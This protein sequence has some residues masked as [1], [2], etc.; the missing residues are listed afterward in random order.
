MNKLKKILTALVMLCL[1]I[2]ILPANTLAVNDDITLRIH[3]YRPDG[4]Y[5]GWNLWL[6]DNDGYYETEPLYQF[7]AGNNEMICTVTVPTG[8]KH[9]GYIVRYGEWE[10]K[11]VEHDQFINLNGILSGT[12]DFYITSGVPSQEAA[13]YVPS[14]DQLC[15]DGFMVLGQDVVFG[16]IVLSA[17][18]SIDYDG[19]NRLDVM[20]SAIP[21]YEVTADLFKVMLQDNI[22][23]SITNIEKAPSYLTP[24]ASSY[25]L[26]LDEELSFDK[27]YSIQFQ[28]SSQ[29]ITM[30]SVHIEDASYETD[31]DFLGIQLHLSPQP[32]L[33]QISTAS[34]FILNQDYDYIAIKKLTKVA[35]TYYL[36]LYQPLKTGTYYIG[37]L[38]NSVVSVTYTCDHPSH[39]SQGICD[40]CADL[41][42]HS[43]EDNGFC[44]CGEKAP[45]ITDPTE[46]P[47]EAAPTTPDVDPTIVPTDGATTTPDEYPTQGQDSKPGRDDEDEADSSQ[48]GSVFDLIDPVTLIAI[49]LLAVGVVAIAAIIIILVK[50]KKG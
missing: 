14:I 50:H 7:E 20:L 11:D 15:S 28:D 43:Y 30:Q 40:D 39:N 46:K 17:K 8:T 23:A 33:D 31:T 38:E 16:C 4:D 5:D 48:S 44:V 9:V 19:R 36:H 3:Y 6:W 21:D 2:S 12:I 42:E 29:T 37:L 32:S 35:D 10:K 1:M 47:T 26:Y 34:F 27:T 24:S 41:V 22:T 25:I 45:D 18:Y 49:T 13:N